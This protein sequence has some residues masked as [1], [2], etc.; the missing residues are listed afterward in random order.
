[1]VGADKQPFRDHPAR[2]I[3]ERVLVNPFGRERLHRL[4]QRGRG[5]VDVLARRSGI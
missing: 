3:V 1:M 2:E 5:I 4:E